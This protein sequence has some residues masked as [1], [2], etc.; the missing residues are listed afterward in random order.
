MRA[1]QIDVNP[2]AVKVVEIE[3]ELTA[4]QEAVGG[5]IEPAHLAELETMGIVLLCDEEGVLYGKPYNA[6]LF[7]YFFVGTV[8]A[9]A[10]NGEE[11]DGL[12]D[13]QL[14]WMQN[15]L[16]KLKEERQ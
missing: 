3:N 12:N 5:Y 9:V 16:A 1:I 14:Y 8:L 10:K 4:L 6:N 15:W 11:F 13:G 2:D 7:P